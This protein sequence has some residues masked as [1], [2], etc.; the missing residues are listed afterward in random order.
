MQSKMKR[1]S[2]VWAAVRSY[3]QGRSRVARVMI[4]CLPVVVLAII[5]SLVRSMPTAPQTL[6]KQ[7]YGEEIGR[8]GLRYK[9]GTHIYNPETGEILVDSISWLHISPGDTIAILAKN[10][11]RAYINLN[12]AK[13][14]TPLAYDKAWEFACNRGIMS[15][16]DSLFIFRRDGSQVN[17]SGLTAGR[18][19]EYLFYENRLALNVDYDHVG[20]LDTAG[21][22]VLEPVYQKIET[23]Y[24]H[25]LYNTRLG[26]E[27]IVYGY[28]L[29]PVLRGAYKTI[30]VDW[31]EG[32][33]ATEHNGI[34]RLFDYEGKLVYQ[35]IYKR[36]ESLEYTHKDKDGKDVTEE[37]DCYV[38][39]DYNDKRGLMDKHYKVLTPPLFHDI[40]AQTKHVFFATFGEYSNRF[41]TLIDDHGKALR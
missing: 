34:Q 21:N 9:I 33:I 20:L 16:N 40:E 22:W 14:I 24:G 26:N 19:Y 3:W 2:S 7:L 25:R 35:V 38:Y 12:T 13:L 32:L 36:I 10:H 17:T 1:L 28:D 27:C 41:G 23:S 6:R 29:K 4:I 18:Q 8:N 31:S 15:R 37:T 11:R 5:C 39:V 30:E